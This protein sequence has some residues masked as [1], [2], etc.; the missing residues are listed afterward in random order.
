MRR[1][2]QRALVLLVVC[3]V[4]FVFSGVA[5]ANDRPV[6]MSELSR[7]VED[8]SP[9]DLL[10]VLAERGVGFRMS[11][12]AE[13]R[14]KKY[15]FTV[16]QIELVRRIAAGEKVDLNQTPVKP[17]S[18]D[19]VA[20]ADGD[21]EKDAGKL[22]VGFTDPDHWHAA[23]QN[24]IERAIKDAG[25]AYKRIELSR[26]TLYSSDAR[27]RKLAPILKKL[28]G[29]LIK[30][31]P[32][33]IASASSPKSTHIVIVDGESEWRNWVDALLD[34]YEKDGMK[35]SFGPDADAKTQLKQGSGFLL[36]ACACAKVGTRSDENVARF[37]TYSLG[38]L[39]MARAGGKGQ[40]VGLKTG[41][42]D[43]AEEIAMGT[44]SVMIYSYE[45]RDLKQEGG[46]KDVVKRQFKEKKITNAASPWGY[47]TS[48]MQPE[49]YAE[50]WSM[51]S[52]LSSAPD[53]FAKAVQAVRED[54]TVMNAA[55]NEVYGV[56]NKKLLE[57]WYK[58]ANR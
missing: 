6:K 52:M 40:P 32:A 50:C 15:G 47:V 56:D 30:R 51:V 8:Q 53:K 27:A 42:G 41:F 24:R 23:E 11:S 28:E 45:K 2:I 17:E 57:A 20:A 12:A 36:P 58:H 25:L 5:L 19:A 10:A 37:A 21:A 35:F 3:A 46:W 9:Q 48:T 4:C 13:G 16:D 49:H 31:F 34:S 22:K 39:M 44:P 14:L 38:H 26:V 55:V 1:Y 7:L 18:D 43:L 29:T 54:E 33:S